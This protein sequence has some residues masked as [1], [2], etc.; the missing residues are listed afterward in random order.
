MASED[1]A[2]WRIMNILLVFI[3]STIGQSKMHMLYRLATC[4]V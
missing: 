3:H 4:T 2:K 1:M